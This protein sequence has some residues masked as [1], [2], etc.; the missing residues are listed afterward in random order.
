MASFG[1]TEDDPLCNLTIPFQ[2]LRS[3]RPLRR[4]YSKIFTPSWIATMINQTFCPGSGLPESNRRTDLVHQYPI[5][6]KCSPAGLPPPLLQLLGPP[7]L[8]LSAD[9][10]KF[11]DDSRL[12]RLKGADLNVV[13][14][15]VGDCAPFLGLDGNA[16]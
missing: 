2:L 10:S 5:S 12:L 13:R 1:M 15:T 16:F 4:D 6:R 9:T 3:T 14:T 7:L 11:E 8:Q